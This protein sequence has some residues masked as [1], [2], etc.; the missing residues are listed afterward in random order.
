MCANVFQCLY[1]LCVPVLFLRLFFLF[2]LSYSGL[3]LSYLIIIIT[4]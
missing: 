1:V 2:V 3:F 4:F